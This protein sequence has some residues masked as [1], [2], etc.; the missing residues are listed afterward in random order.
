MKDCST[1][2][3]IIGTRPSK[4]QDILFQRTVLLEKKQKKRKIAVLTCVLLEEGLHGFRTFCF[5]EQL[6][7]KKQKSQKKRKIAVPTY[8]LLAQGIDERGKI[9][10]NVKFKC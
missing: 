5:S 6:F 9:V 3:R 2:L 4:I 10:A 8:V 7:R 1:Y